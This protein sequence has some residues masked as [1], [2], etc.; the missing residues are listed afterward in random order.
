MRPGAVHL[1]SGRRE[2]KDMVRVQD[3]SESEAKRLQRIVRRGAKDIITWRR[4][5]V[6]LASA[7]GQKVSVIGRG[8]SSP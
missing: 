4:A 3:L 7:Q 2:E 6:V 8:A 5:T 1:F